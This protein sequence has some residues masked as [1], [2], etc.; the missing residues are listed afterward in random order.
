MLW[1]LACAPTPCEA[2]WGRARDGT[3]VA[4]A[5][6][7]VADAD[8]DPEADTGGPGE[9]GVDRETGDPG[10]CPAGPWPT[11]SDVDATAEQVCEKFTKPCNHQ[12]RLAL[13]SG[14]A[15]RVLEAPVA[16]HASVPDPAWIAHGTIDGEPWYELR[17]AY[18]DAAD[19]NRP[20]GASQRISVAALPVSESELGDTELAAAL[21]GDGRCPWVH[22]ATNA[23][24]HGGN[25]VDPGLEVFEAEDGELVHLM[26]ALDNLVSE[27]TSYKSEKHLTKSWWLRLLSSADGFTY[28]RIGDVLE[29][30]VADDGSRAGVDPDLFP[31]GYAGDYPG[32][33]PSAWLPG[34]SGPWGLHL[35][36]GG[37]LNLFEGELGEALARQ[38]T[39]TTAGSVST[40][41]VLD[42]ELVLHAHVAVDEEFADIVRIERDADGLYGA[43]EV[44]LATGDEG[45]PHGGFSPSV[46]PLPG[47]L[48][49][50][51]L[52]TAIDGPDAF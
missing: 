22:R 36:S 44:V 15:W 9:T 52:H 51:V 10:S 1:L 40:T 35:S 3:C 16:L 30:A 27:G 31:L 20:E 5:D 48:Q 34:G 42:G 23:H 45:L 41:S 14:A 2:G 50:M 21:A 17:I 46:V 49:L 29:L 33:L 37:E 32:V 47:G 8:T 38:G 26:V 19:T 6:G 12:V 24:E 13:G 7:S 43:A 11:T 28:E 4:L 25:L 39:A 18:V